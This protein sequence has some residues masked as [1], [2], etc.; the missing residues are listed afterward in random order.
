MERKIQISKK[1]TANIDNLR[2]YNKRTSENNK[3]VGQYTKST[4]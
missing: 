2:Y 3:S 4:T 1:K